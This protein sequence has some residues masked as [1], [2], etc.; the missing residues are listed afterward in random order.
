MRRV[1]KWLRNCTVASA[2]LAGLA[3]EDHHGQV[4]FGG[5]PVPGATVTAVP[6]DGQGARRMAAITDQQGAYVFSGITDGVWTIRVEMLCFEPIQAEVAIAPDAPS[7]V[8][9]LKLLSFD[10]I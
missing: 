6:R 4:T 2:A 8:W 1:R 7:P 5:L 9:E 3:A 10:A